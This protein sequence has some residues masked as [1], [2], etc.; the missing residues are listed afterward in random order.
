MSEAKLAAEV[1][2]SH[3]QVQQLQRQKRAHRINNEK[4]FRIHPELRTMMSSFMS[5][6]LADKPEKVDEYAERYFT[7][8]ELARKLGFVGWTRPSTPQPEAPGMVF[9]EEYDESELNPEVAGDTGMDEVELEQLLISLFKEADKDGSGSLDHAE[10]TEL[11]ATASLGLSKQEVKMLLAEADENNDGTITYQEFV[12]LAVETVQTMRL[13]QRYV[14]YEED[15]AYELLEAAMAIVGQTAEQFND[16]VAAA[17]EKLGT[18]GLFSRNQLKALLKSPALGLSKQQANQAAHAVAYDGE[19]VVSVATLSTTLYDIVL[20]VVADA[21]RQQNLGEVGAELTAIFTHYDKSGSG[22]IEVKVARTALLQSFEFIT[23]L[24]ATALFNDAPT[25]DEGLV[26][27]KAFLPKLTAL[28]KAMGDPMAI[29]ERNALA[30]RSNFT[31]MEMMS[32]LD[33]QQFESTIAALFKDADKDGNGTLDVHEFQRLLGDSSIGLKKQEID[34]LRN[35]FDTD[36]SGDI[37]LAEFQDIA[38]NVLGQISRER[39]IM[40][41]MDIADGY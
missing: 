23:R 19:G 18:G 5:S 28:L 30:I 12:P 22:F 25:N 38:Y 26:D 36:H 10:F 11:M 20:N 1:K 40:E 24:Q 32:H 7:D 14:E 34:G 27:W 8:P 17:G 3:S 15:M 2:L 41:A 37:S 31:P 21:L 33:K 9:E 39:A 4:Y 16:F 6:L 29:R 13:K 35:Y